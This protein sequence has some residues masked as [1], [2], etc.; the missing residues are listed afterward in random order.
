[1]QSKQLTDLKLCTQLVILHSASQNSKFNIILWNDAAHWL[2][3]LFN[4]TALSCDV[5]FIIFDKQNVL[6]RIYH[7]KVINLLKY[8]IFVFLSSTFLIFR[9]IPCVYNSS[10]FV[11]CEIFVH[12]PYT[13]FLG[14]SWI[15][16]GLQSKFF[17]FFLFVCFA[18]IQHVCCAGMRRIYCAQI[19]HVVCSDAAWGV[20]WYSVFAVLRCDV[21]CA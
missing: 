6:W 18:R 11:N 10:D 2:S 4:W 15:F 19:R 5:L 20:L 3:V 14:I 16:V 17:P 1:M 8:N 21:C 9:P 13:Y 7:T 12:F